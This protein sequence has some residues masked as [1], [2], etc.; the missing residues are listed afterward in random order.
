MTVKVLD[1][2]AEEFVTEGGVTIR[3][4]RHATPYAGAI[5]AYRHYLALRSDPE[6]A[7]RPDADRIREE[8]R[9]LERHP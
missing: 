3:R 2:G 4:E 8:L 1:D 7:L 9:R 6:P 5:E